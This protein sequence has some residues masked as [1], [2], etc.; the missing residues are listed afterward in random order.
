MCQERQVGAARVRLVV[1][2]SS[3]AP[4]VVLRINRGQLIEATDCGAS[5]GVFAWLVS[6]IE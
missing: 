6:G 4:S 1:I 2:P 3:V 5:S